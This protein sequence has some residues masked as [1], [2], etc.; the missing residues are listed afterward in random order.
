VAAA[1]AAAT[2]S[3]GSSTPSNAPENPPPTPTPEVIPNH[4]APALESP[5]LNSIINDHIPELRQQIEASLPSENSIDHNSQL[6]E[7]IRE[8]GSMLAHETL[9][10]ISEL[11]VCVPQL[12][13]DIKGIGNQ[14][15]PDAILRPDLGQEITPLKNYEELIATGHETIDELFSTDNAE[16]YPKES[17]NR[18]VL[19]ILPP[20]GFFTNIADSLKQL[21]DASKVIDRAGFTKAGRG[22]MKHGYREKTVFPKPTGNPSHINEHGQK[23]L[24]SILNHPERTV[25]VQET[26]K[27]GHAIDIFAPNLGGVRYNAQGEFIGF[28]EPKNAK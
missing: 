14:I 24:D 9:E 2:A 10:T 7:Q 23:I 17:D 16:L 27:H 18:F 13:E 5:V 11:I 12:L 25:S 6:S 8:F 15:L 21:S 22:L 4:S 3:N 19:G 20:P 28:L 26:S 1:A